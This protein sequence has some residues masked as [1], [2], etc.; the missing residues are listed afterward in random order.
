[1]AIWEQ[2]P[3]TNFHQ[4]NLDW[5][6]NSIKNLDGRVDELEAGGGGATKDY[7]DEQDNKLTAEIARV[8]TEC[9]ENTTNISRDLNTEV[10]NRQTADNLIDNNINQVKADVTSIKQSIGEWTQPVTMSNA[11]SSVQ[12]TSGKSA[13]AIHGAGGTY[14]L[15]KGT[16]QARLNN[17]ETTN[18]L[19]V[20]RKRITYSA[21]VG[22][23]NTF[24]VSATV[25]AHTVTTYSLPAVEVRAYTGAKLTN[26]T[27]FVTS[28]GNATTP[29]QVQFVPYS[30]NAYTATGL[31]LLINSNSDPITINSTALRVYALNK[32]DT[33]VVV[34]VTGNVADSKTSDVTKSYVDS[35]DAV[36]DAKITT[37]QTTAD[38][39]VTM[40][41]EASDKAETASGVANSAK[42]SA[43]NAKTSADNAKTAADGATETA[44]T[45]NDNATKAI[46]AIGSKSAAVTFSNLWAAIGAWNESATIT[47]RL[48]DAYNWAWNSRSAINGSTNYP[49]DK[50][51]INAR[52]NALEE[53]SGSSVKI[54]SGNG[55]L[56][57]RT[58]EEL[59]V[60][61]ASAGFTETPNVIASYCKTGDN[62]ADI[63]GIVKVWNVNKTGCKISITGGAVG[64]SYTV[65]WIANG[66]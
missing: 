39:A 10:Q 24:D 29:I 30:L 50:A 56:G 45:A 23:S 32:D 25:N 15:S 47:A 54:V 13:N 43:D 1:M 9:D 61:F 28:A 48:K 55:T 46:A 42:T 37:A 31:I 34:D 41:T 53:N 18:E 26:L 60:D 8:E 44:H 7:V 11:V 38:S 27:Y 19:T 14:D 63:S 62:D 33:D 5:V 3:F 17:L 12:E 6:L 36:L 20:K 35:Q 2:F 49:T 58:G 59:T 16:I 51:T 52:L 66:K 64:H 4:E 65:A 40:A 57:A 22:E 21:V